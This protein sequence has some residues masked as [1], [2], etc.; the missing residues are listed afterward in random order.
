M[1]EWGALSSGG[2][3]SAWESFFSVDSLSFNSQSLVKPRLIISVVA[4]FMNF[5]STRFQQLWKTVLII[6]QKPSFNLQIALWD[7]KIFCI[8]FMQFS[9][10]LLSSVIWQYST[11]LILMWTKQNNKLSIEGK[12]MSLI[13]W[14]IDKSFQQFIHT[15]HTTQRFS[16]QTNSSEL[17]FMREDDRRRLVIQKYQPMKSHNNLKYILKNV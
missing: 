15:L 2:Y 6:N 1:L 8:E 11:A 9:G 12:I 16:S 3:C 10:L 13:F 7:E 5:E 14:F 4:T 17:T